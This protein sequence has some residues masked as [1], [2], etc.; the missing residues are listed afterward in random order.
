M[1]GPVEKKS[2][3]DEVENV[4]AVLYGVDDLR[5]VT[6]TMYCTYSSCDPTGRVGEAYSKAW[7]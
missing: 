2:R 3:T 6:V 7:R 5:I 1:E 4:A